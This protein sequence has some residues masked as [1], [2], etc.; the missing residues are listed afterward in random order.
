MVLR[1]FQVGNLLLTQ[2][3]AISSSSGYRKSHILFICLHLLFT[4]CP[5]VFLYHQMI[6]LCR[7]ATSYYSSTTHEAY[8]TD[9][10]ASLAHLGLS[11]HISTASLLVGCYAVVCVCFISFPAWNSRV[12][13][14]MCR[15]VSDR[16]CVD[17]EAFIFIDNSVTSKIISLASINNC[18][19]DDCLANCNIFAVV[20]ETLTH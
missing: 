10:C 12:T 2:T 17:A 8:V 15:F 7:L 6:I 20:T 13:S 4:F 19:C 5:T 16:M 1:H 14:G 11:L 3:L 9:S 18:D